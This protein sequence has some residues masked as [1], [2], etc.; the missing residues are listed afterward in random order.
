MG[1]QKLDSNTILY[2]V[3]GDPIRH[4]KSPIMLNRAFEESGINA[5][6]AAFHIKPGQL[7]SA[8]EGIRALQFRGVNVTI[9]HKVEVMDY[10]DEID[11]GAR[12]IGAVNTI[13]NE[14]G[15]LIGH[16]TD[17]IGYVRSLKEE[18]GIDL[19]GKHILMLGAGGAAR[20]VG[21]ALAMEGAAHIYIANR[22]RDK[23]IELAQSMSSFTTATGLGLDEIGDIVG[24]V[25]LIVNNTSVGMHPNINDVPMD[26]SLILDST[27]VSDLVYNPLVTKFLRESE[28]RGATIHSGLGMFIYQ[29]AYAFEYWTGA[30]APVAAMRQAVIDSFNT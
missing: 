29:G 6:Y 16:N 13:V 25:G 1:K 9:P 19:R 4:S 24:K 7:K 22:T 5:A 26:T 15:R 12:I 21:Y 2:G 10:M 27:V 11:E 8:I 18:T 17:G 3:F 14:D 30:S 28:S 23:A 20:G